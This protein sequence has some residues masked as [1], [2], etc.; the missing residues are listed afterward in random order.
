MN[1]EHDLSILYETAA[2][3]TALD[4]IR[5]SSVV[6]D[7][8]FNE[9]VAI[10]E[11]KVFKNKKELKKKLDK[12][13][14]SPKPIETLGSYCIYIIKSLLP[15]A[16]G[17]AGIHGI[18]ALATAGKI[19]ATAAGSAMV[20]VSA[21]SIIVFMVIDCCTRINRM[22]GSISD[23]KI[24]YKKILNAI[25]ESIKAWKRKDGD[26]AK[27]MLSKLEEAKDKVQAKLDALNALAKKHN[28]SYQ[29]TFDESEFDAL[30]SFDDI[31]LD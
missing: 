9:A 3:D 20:A 8:T 6:P 18:E 17:F 26:N 19:S 13:E 16:G 23:K 5:I 24:Q 21:I 10:L 27:K 25:N 2:Y 7:Q 28:L 30:L 31:R 14:K 29:N 1:I 11:A 22:P 4:V 12:L 15:V